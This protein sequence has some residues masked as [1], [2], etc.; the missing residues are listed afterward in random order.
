MGYS[1]PD[2]QNAQLRF[3]NNQ[4]MTVD[5][6]IARQNQMNDYVWKS[7]NAVEKALEEHDRAIE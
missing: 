2:G 1:D 3:N 4:E 7:E 6:Q 5:E